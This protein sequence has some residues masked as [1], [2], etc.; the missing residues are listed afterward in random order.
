MISKKHSQLVIILIVSMTIIALIPL[1]SLKFGFSIEALYPSG[2]EDLSFYREFRHTFGTETEDEFIFIGLKNGGGIFDSGF[3][4]K[5]D[6]LTRFLGG[7][8]PVVKL[9]SPTNTNIIYFSNDQIN[10]RPLI[11]INQPEKYPSDSAY[12]FQSKEYRDLLVSRDGKAIAIGAFNSPDLDEGQKRLLV[13]S[14]R[15]KIDSLRFDEVHFTAKI[16]AETIYL[17]EIRKNL[18]KYSAASFLVIC[19]TLMIVFR[20]FRFVLFALLVTVI[21]I[22]WTL[23]LMSAFDYSLDIVSSLIPPLLATICMSGI[24]HI[25]SRYRDELVKGG[26]K[27]VALQKTI[28]ANLVPVFLAYATTA[29]G[30]FSLAI[31]DIAPL[32]IFGRFAGTGVLISFVLCCF[33]LPALYRF[34][35]APVSAKPSG[36]HWTGFLSTLFQQLKKHRYAVL[37]LFAL[38]T[39]AS[40][41]FTD[42]IEINS[43]LLEELPRRHS[44]LEDYHFMEENFSGT[45]PFEIAL[46]VKDR[47]NSLMDSSMMKKIEEIENFLKDSCRVGHLISPVSLFKGAN[48]AFHGGEIT[49]FVIPLQRD[50]PRLYEAIMQTEHADEMEHYMLAD[51]SRGRISGRLPDLSTRQFA[52]LSEQFGNFF[53]RNHYD[54][55]LSYRMTGSALLL[56]KISA[57]L[58][59][60]LFMGL[61]IAFL[62]IAVIAYLLLKKWYVM[63][64]ALAVNIIPLLITGAVMAVADIHLKADTAVIF[65]IAFGIVVDNTIHMLGR[66]RAELPHAKSFADALE[67]AYLATGKPITITTL[68]LLA[69]FLVLLSSSFG[70]VFY[71][72]LLVSACLFSGLIASMVLLPVLLL[73]LH[74]FSPVKEKQ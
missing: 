24:I 73:I 50:V 26:K 55:A 64:V 32:K 47:K 10:A 27:E 61:A 70:S 54:S 4:K 20:S 18:V 2:D 53:Y 31:T 22:I 68:V 71:I 8:E 34:A 41:Y 43:S 58:T 6:S 35:P 69:G 33:F 3:L 40:V 65:S 16:R 25:T 46:A 14:I 9:Y 17:D 23:A 72:G 36:S 19:L 51:G 29:L 39:A 44:I 12:L 52:K 28:R 38:L 74:R 56:D 66:M 5:T 60:N 62:L 7:L 1:H 63:F 37:L 15:A 13:D 42:K 21:T 11:H 30:F 67:R 45:R 49:R 57:S 59:R 48:K